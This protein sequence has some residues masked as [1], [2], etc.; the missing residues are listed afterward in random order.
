M[1][2]DSIRLTETERR[3]IEIYLSEE[4]PLKAKEI[5]ERLGVSV[6]TVYKAL[7]KFRKMGKNRYLNTS[8]NSMDMLIQKTLENLLPQIKDIIAREI[9]R[10]VGSE[11]S[12]NEQ[13]LNLMRE[14][15]QTLQDLKKSID[16]LAL[17][18]DR[19]G[20]DRSRET[21]GIHENKISDLPSFLLDNP[22]IDRIARLSNNRE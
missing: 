9:E 19:L 20:E 10:A 17:S 8:V 18:V 5:A 15:V 4:K 16:K 22:W 13:Y 6:R 2:E 21:I 1:D 12:S 3:I 7:Y 11:S 14:L